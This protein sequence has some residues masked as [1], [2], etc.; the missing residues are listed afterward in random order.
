MCWHWW[1]QPAECNS[2]EGACQILHSWHELCSHN[3]EDVDTDTS[4]VYAPLLGQPDE[5][6]KVECIII[7]R[8]I[9]DAAVR[10][11]LKPALGCGIG[12]H[13]IEHY[14]S[15]ESEDEEEVCPYVGLSEDEMGQDT[16]NRLE[17]ADTLGSSLS[18]RK[19]TRRRLIQAR[20]RNA[21]IAAAE[22]AASEANAA[23]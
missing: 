2:K 1:A 4:N 21:A 10:N 3:F 23:N 19:R 18:A 6:G 22:A 9:K 5:N 14:E 11:G 17:I 8:H 13:A 16:I 7:P 12:S 20:R 15:S